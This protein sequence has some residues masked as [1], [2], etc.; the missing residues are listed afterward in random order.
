MTA[1][2]A[3]SARDPD[4]S[5]VGI[6]ADSGA[7]A[8][9]TGRSTERAA[10]AGGA[11]P[12]ADLAGRVQRAEVDPYDP[13]VI[14]AAARLDEAALEALARGLK[15]GGVGITAWRA[16][17]KSARRTA[18]RAAAA[19]RRQAE[20]EE[21]D[22]RL[23]SVEILEVGD[24]VELAKRILAEIREETGEDAVF[25]ARRLW[26]YDRARGIWTPRT[27]EALECLVHPYSGRLV[28]Q[29]DSARP[30]KLSGA[31]IQ[32]TTRVMCARCE[33][34][35]FFD[36][37]PPGLCFR[38]RWV[39]AHSGEVVT[40][41]HHPDHRARHHID[42][43]YEFDAP[44]GRWTATLREVLVRRVPGTGTVDPETGEVDPATMAIDEADTEQSIALLQ[45]FV[46]A[47]LLGEATN[48]Q[49][50]L[51]LYGAG[52][53]GKSTLIDVIS[54]LFSE[55]SRSAVPP[56]DWTRAFA[57]A[58]LSGKAINIATELP[59]LEFN[60]ERF[61]TIIAGETISAEYKR[62]DPF[63]FRP[64]AAHIFAA[65]R[66]PPTRAHTDGFWRRFRV[67]VFERFFT[68]EERVAGLAKTI[69]A[70]E[71]AGVAAWAI[72][73]AARRQTLRSYTTP[74]S[75][76]V[77]LREWRSS[78]DPVRQWLDDEVEITATYAG[79]LDPLYESYQRWCTATGHARTL[80]RNNF[81]ERLRSLGHF[82]RTATARLYRLRVRPTTSGDE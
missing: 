39:T 76:E 51:V 3:S 17:V 46:G 73:G 5:T 42:V 10:A 8:S 22:R 27:D 34:P 16:A 45:E 71:L 72:E 43:D 20:T 18:A 25:D 69:L 50:C 65:N 14:A 6:A 7:T 75:S 80:A 74:Q 31:A 55:G 2:S 38:D 12:L 67:L 77:A 61:N 11:D 9:T 30:L 41:P 53:N 66:L 57:V 79:R 35:G 4:L 36:D 82:R 23:S 19:E 1:P 49:A 62:K 64:R 52:A 21:R 26:I 59:S 13:V 81:G 24:V 60:P 32:A 37:A 58:T 78:T 68:E 29:G 54:G 70:E 33:R 28:A 15:G 47:A 63:D 48:Y 56:S 44:R 40:E